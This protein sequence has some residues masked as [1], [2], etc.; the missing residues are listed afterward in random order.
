MTRLPWLAGGSRI[1][2]T[3]ESGI[4]ERIGGEPETKMT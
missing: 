1:R 3:N 4:V 2:A